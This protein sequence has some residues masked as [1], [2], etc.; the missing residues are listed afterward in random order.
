LPRATWSTSSERRVRASER[1]MVVIWRLLLTC[2][3]DQFSSRLPRSDPSPSAGSVAGN[4]KSGTL[5]KPRP[6]IGSASPSPGHTCLR[7][8]LLRYIQSRK[9]LSAARDVLLTRTKYTLQRVTVAGETVLP[10]DQS[11]RRR[12]VVLPGS[13]RRLLDIRAG[14][15]LDAT[16]ERGRI[17]LTPR[18]KRLHP[19]KLVTDPVT[20]LPALSAGPNA[21]TLSSREVKEIFA[22]FL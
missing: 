13:L 20:G 18:K 6:R 15:P 11:L 4:S 2:R 19:V 8:L 22:S 9:G 1:P 7:S 3:F 16:I 12:E 10:A 5:D 21:P 14:D 17:V